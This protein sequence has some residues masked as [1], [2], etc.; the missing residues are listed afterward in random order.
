MIARFKDKATAENFGLTPD[1]EGTVT[2]MET[3]DGV[4]YVSVLF[5]GVEVS[6]VSAS[7]FIY[8]NQ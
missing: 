1:D 7:L 3:R 4:S 2:A 5:D 8:R 6:G